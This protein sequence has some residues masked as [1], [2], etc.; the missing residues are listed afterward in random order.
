MKR[1]LILASGLTALFGG[2]AFAESDWSRVKVNVYVNPML[3][4]ATNE[5]FGTQ[6][7]RQNQMSRRQHT[8][9][10]SKR[11][12]GSYHIE[13]GKHFHHPQ[14]PGGSRPVVMKRGAVAHVEDLAQR[15]KY[16][17]NLLCLD[18][19]DNYRHNRGYAET[20]REAYAV[21]GEAQR[22]EADGASADHAELATMVREVEAS[23][24]PIRREVTG[25]NRQ[26]NRDRGQGGLQVKLQRM[27]SLI[28]H[29]RHDAVPARKIKAV[30]IKP[31]LDLN[32]QAVRTD[33][34]VVRR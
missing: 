4:R 27:E 19:A 14:E 32:A 7:R 13:N 31:H 23:L 30:A 2:A 33:A 24:H 1:V 22:L 16:E 5:L 21:L 11:F 8:V 9:T 10:S 12:P 20:Y 6:N 15:L 3:L 25:W 18:L 17:A 26:N 34:G 29:L 28:H